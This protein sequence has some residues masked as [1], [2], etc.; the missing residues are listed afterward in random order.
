MSVTWRFIPRLPVGRMRYIVLALVAAILL[1]SDLVIAQGK[2]EGTKVGSS[3]PAPRYF[4]AGIFGGNPSISA[5]R[6]DWYS[7][8]LTAMD[9]PSLM[10]AGMNGD[11]TTYRFTLILSARAMS[12]R[13]KVY[14]DG[15]GTLATKRVIVYPDKPNSLRVEEASVS[16]EQ[17]REF[18]ATVQKNGFWSSEPERNNQ[19]NRGR[20]EGMQLILEGVQNR[21]Y[22][23][24]DRWCPKDPDFVKACIYLMKLTHAPADNF[25]KQLGGGSPKGTN[26]YQG[27][28]RP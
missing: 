2:G 10:E 3:E 28:S 17:V 15:S 13:L 4:P 11:V 21:T 26:S 1:S 19:R 16:K 7:F 20:L 5:Y 18:V 24:V 8:F 22:H 23:V 14:P 6:E 9:E 12:F 27:Q 25:A